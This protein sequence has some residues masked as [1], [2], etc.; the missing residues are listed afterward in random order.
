MLGGTL[1][2]IWHSMISI[3]RTP[4]YCAGYPISYNIGKYIEYGFYVL[5][6]RLKT[7]KLSGCPVR[8]YVVGGEAETKVRDLPAESQDQGSGFSGE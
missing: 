7:G 5:R 1:P 8:Q 6:E 4:H 2:K 3:G